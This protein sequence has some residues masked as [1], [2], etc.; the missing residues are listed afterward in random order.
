VSEQSQAAQVSAAS[1]PV[2]LRLAPAA[3]EATELQVAEEQLAYANL[4]DSS[5]KLG[6]LSLVATFVLYL[7]G[8]LPPHLPVTDLPRYWAL[9]VR[10]Y[11]AATGVRPGWAWLH[12]LGKGDF[13]NYLGIAFLSSVTI[14]C[15]LSLIP[16]FRKKGNRIYSW[17]SIVEVAVLALAASGILTAGGH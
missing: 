10:E 8:V 1:G 13:L 9:P 6:F 3:L 7:S 15:Y 11:L 4:L 12:L 14:L 17:L 16:I 5:M 2:A